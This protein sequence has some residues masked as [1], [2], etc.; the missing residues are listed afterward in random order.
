MFI[1]PFYSAYITKAFLFLSVIIFYMTITI[2]TNAITFAIV[3]G[4]TLGLATSLNYIVRG[5]VTGMSGIAFGLISP[6]KSTK[7]LR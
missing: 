5:K 1:P 7:K 2:D 3:G 4:L 6:S